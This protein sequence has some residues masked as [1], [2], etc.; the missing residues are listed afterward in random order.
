LLDQALV[1]L[2]S[3]DRNAVLLRF[4]ENKSF[5]EIGAALGG[6]ENSARVR[7]VRALE[8]LRSHFRRRGVTLS[9]VALSG[10]L[11]SH[12]VQ[13]APGEL[14]SA[15]GANALAAGTSTVEAV[16]GAVLRRLRRER[17]LRLG[18]RIGLGLLLVAAA[19]FT[20]KPG[21]DSSGS[22]LTAVSRTLRDT[23]ILIDREFSRDNPDGFVELIRF[24]SADEER[25][26]PVLTNYVHVAFRFRQELRRAFNSQQRPFDVTF[27]ELFVGQPPVLTNSIGPDHAHTNVMTARYPLHFIKI[28]EA[29]YWDWFD[30][31]STTTR[32]QRFA[33]LQSRARQ[34]DQL[35]TAVRKGTATNLAEV[36]SAVP[37]PSP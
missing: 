20:F 29:W 33:A 7:V 8:K 4:F 10:I 16:A 22:G 13:A 17:W 19:F 34:F 31:L 9:A 28:K 27:R 18:Q 24:R 30:G 32:D 21:P 36:L 25:F 14:V 12:A 1:R 26:K 5:G 6:N 23:L 15:L 11:M 35:A 37:D 3:K 2:S